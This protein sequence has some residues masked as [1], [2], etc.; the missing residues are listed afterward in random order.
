MPG[1]GAGGRVENSHFGG[2]TRAGR[3]MPSR[4]SRIS[5]PSSRT[6][7][8]P[9]TGSARLAAYRAGEAQLAT[10]APLRFA[11]DGKTARCDTLLLIDGPLA[12]GF[13]RGLTVPVK[14]Y[15]TTAGAFS[16]GA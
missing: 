10:G 1:L 4:T 2:A 13:V 3:T 7:G 8:A 14:G 9:L 5:R 15:A 16:I 11:W 12:N 6:A